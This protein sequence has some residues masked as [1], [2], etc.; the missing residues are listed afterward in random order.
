MLKR[1]RSR[2]APE[3]KKTKYLAINLDVDLKM[4]SF[5]NWYKP[6]SDTLKKKKKKKK[7]QKKKKKKVLN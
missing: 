2:T 7:K 6:Y 4:L 3:A 1:N 5:V